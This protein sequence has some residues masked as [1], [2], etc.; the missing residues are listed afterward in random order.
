[1]NMLNPILLARSDSAQNTTNRA[2][3]TGGDTRIIPP[4]GIK[5]NSP[6]N[7]DVREAQSIL[8]FIGPR[9]QDYRYIAD[10]TANDDAEPSKPRSAGRVS[11]GQG[12]RDIGVNSGELAWLSGGIGFYG[13]L[14]GDI[15]VIFQVSRILDA[16]SGNDP[17]SKYYIRNENGSLDY[18]KL[19]NAISQYK[20]D[21]GLRASPRISLKLLY[22]INEDLAD[23]KIDL[24]SPAAAP[25]PISNNPANNELLGRV[26]NTKLESVT[27][28]L[29][30][31]NLQILRESALREVVN[32]DQGIRVSASAISAS[33]DQIGELIDCA[34]DIIGG[35]MIKGKDRFYLSWSDRQGLVIN[36]KINWDGSV[37]ASED[38]KKTFVALVGTEKA[39]KIDFDKELIAEIEGRVI[40]NAILAVLIEASKKGGAASGID[41]SIVRQMAVKALEKRYQRN[42][43]PGNRPNVVPPETAAVPNRQPSVPSASGEPR[44]IPVAAGSEQ[45]RPPVAPER[46]PEMTPAPKANDIV[47]KSI[48]I[49]EGSAGKAI[50]KQI[51]DAFTSPNPSVRV[52]A[53]ETLYILL[54]DVDAPSLVNILTSILTTMNA[55]NPVDRAAMVASVKVLIRIHEENPKAITKDVIKVLQ[56]LKKTNPP[57][58]LLDAVNL[59]LKDLGVS[60]VPRHSRASELT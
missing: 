34:H 29:T 54:K 16:L 11:F 48:V 39:A 58:E 13:E 59:A 15:N 3:N 44:P 19:A 60:Y 27:N 28:K 22:K 23:K 17:K 30:N 18:A 25:S 52:L 32:R 33:P 26:A 21:L 41:V 2:A 40:G 45:K 35:I 31:E 38:V 10:I 8:I 51:T 5:I 4:E 47:P 37:V 49:P 56:D 57:K 7:E 6:A 12:Y 50:G 20:S 24:P 55:Q 53:I 9:A 14:S 43:E 42:I 1:M 36:G 46:A